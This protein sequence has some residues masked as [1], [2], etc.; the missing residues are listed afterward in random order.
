MKDGTQTSGISAGARCTLNTPKTDLARSIAGWG[1]GLGLI[2][3]S[4]SWGLSCTSDQL[5]TT[6]WNVGRRQDKGTRD[7]F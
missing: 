1:L 7:S 4:I 6:G 3:F 5:L 2:T